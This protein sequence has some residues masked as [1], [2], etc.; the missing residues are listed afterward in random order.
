VSYLYKYGNGKKGENT[1]FVRVETK[2]EGIRMFL[3]IRDFR[4]M[5]E[6]RLKIY[7]YFHRENKLQLVF[8]DEFLCVRGNCEY[9]NL[10]FP[11]FTDGDFEKI[12]G[13]VILDSQGL[14]YGSCWD[15]RE[16][17]EDLLLP[18]EKVEQK[19]LDETDLLEEPDP[20]G[21]LELKEEP[22]PRGET[23]LKEEP[24]PRGES[25]LREE[26]KRRE[27]LER[28]E[29]LNSD[30]TAEGIEEREEK[31]NLEKQDLEG[32][33]SMWEGYPFILFD[34]PENM[35]SAVRIRLKDITRLSSKDWKLAD[36]EFLK[37]SYEQNQHLMVGKLKMQNEKEIWILGVP[38][39]YNNR[40]KYLAGIFGFTNYIPVENREYKTGGKGY[41]IR[42]IEDVE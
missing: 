19:D 20:R 32:E 15:E 17:S 38:G 40:E 7:F 14:L 8:V 27:E 23:E 29:K 35:I 30:E 36:N 31:Q 26:S 18:N 25:E 21:E 4:M 39:I 16:L 41:W 11:D 42:Q 37:Q 22:D 28:T 24:D 34:D 33:L 6:R 3:K 10:V 13:V 1:G 9:R 12:T 5:D 2:E